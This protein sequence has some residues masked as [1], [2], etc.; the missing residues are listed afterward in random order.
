[1]PQVS[2]ILLGVLACLICIMGASN[3]RTIYLSTATGGNPWTGDCTSEPGDCDINTA[4][5]YVPGAIAVSGTTPCEVVFTSSGSIN[6]LDW[7]IVS[8]TFTLSLESSVEFVNAQFTVAG[9]MR[10]Q[11]GTPLSPAPIISG[12]IDVR[13]LNGVSNLLVLEKL[14]LS[15][16]AVTYASHT[17]NAV[18]RLYLNIQDCDI[19]VPSTAP[20][21][22]AT[23]L[24]VPGNPATTTAS[25][26]I[27][28]SSTNYINMNDAPVSRV[29]L[30]SQLTTSSTDDIWVSF[31]GM[32][33]FP[34]MAPMMGTALVD[35]SGGGTLTFSACT[36][37]TNMGYLMSK[38]TLMPGLILVDT[39]TLVS[40]SSITMVGSSTLSLNSDSSMTGFIIT[41]GN[42]ELSDNS[43]IINGQVSV[44]SP[45]QIEVIS[46]TAG[47]YL[48]L[49]VSP[50]PISDVTFDSAT[51]SIATG[52]T[53]QFSDYSV[54]TGG[55]VY[56]LFGDVN[57]MNPSNSPCKWVADSYI[58]AQ[59]DAVVT[60]SCD[61]SFRKGITGGGSATQFGGQTANAELTFDSASV[62]TEFTATLDSFSLITVHVNPANAA[63]GFA[64]TGSLLTLH[65]VPSAIRIAWP[66]SGAPPVRDTVL[67][68]LPNHP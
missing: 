15:N 25:V 17:A 7:N 28:S 62:Y 20:V 5:E 46:G 22:G 8:T 11:D 45:R 40:P 63:S 52:A 61:T 67:L 58:V 2:T 23:I 16:A 13:T 1:M 30:R 4:C 3:A 55:Y 36:L 41:N 32:Q 47:I 60:T 14:H 64:V 34:A 54:D 43:K 68:P 24:L 9:T 65:G 38:V 29:F 31:A 51:V 59:S 44:I 50:A 48:D 53:L 27:I 56:N 37:Y 19:T 10:I 12:S 18:S 35:V 6:G 66:S 26:Q 21:T 33:S 39:S 42:I 57:V 49:M